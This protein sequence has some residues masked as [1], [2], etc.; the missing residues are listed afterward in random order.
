MKPED[1]VTAVKEAFGQYP[2]DVLGPI[3]MADEAFGW[4]HEV[5]VS[6]QREVEDE[7]FA[8]RIVKLASAGAYLADGIGSYCG[9]EHATMWQKLQE[10]GVIPPDRRQLD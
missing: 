1:L 10:A 3:K 8:A 7:N 6:I 4:L 5:F 2:E 9:A